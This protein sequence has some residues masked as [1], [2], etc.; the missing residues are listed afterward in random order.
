MTPWVKRLL[1]AN[2]AVYFL[3]LALPVTT[4]FLAFI[5]SLALTR[6][7]SFVTYMFAHDPA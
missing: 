6:P 3:Q 5:P 4:D 7:W 1:I 2:V